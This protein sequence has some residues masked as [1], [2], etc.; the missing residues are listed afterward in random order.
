[1]AIEPVVFLI[2]G[3][4]A[5]KTNF[6]GR[7]WLCL[8]SKAG[9]LFADTLP[10]DA[11]YLVQVSQE[12]LKGKYAG[13]TPFGTETRK[14]QVPVSWKEGSIQHSGLVVLPD[15][16]GEQWTKDFQNRVWPSELDGLLTE[17]AG[18]LLFIRA[19]SERITPAIDPIKYAELFVFKAD[20]EA[21]TPKQL[22]PNVDAKTQSIRIE[23]EEEEEEAA[24]QTD[25]DDNKQNEP[26]D[27]DNTN[28]I[29]SQM[30]TQV[31][32]VDWLQCL[33]QAF[34]E[35]CGC[36]FTPRIGIVVTAWDLVP[37]DQKKVGVQGY[38]K[39][40]FPMLWQFVRANSDRFQ[41]QLFGTSVAGVDLEIDEDRKKYFDSNPRLAGFVLH[42]LNGAD[43]TSPDFT[44][45]L[46]WALGAQAQ[47]N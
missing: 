13:H 24:Q 8:R 5:G 38:L 47:S 40:I 34:D 2:G 4:D 7:L 22:A 30:P 33:R 42:S 16:P 31:V 29:D 45:P 17:K 36:E 14:C 18:C 39:H 27:D 15:R 10:D 32:L 9:Q 20:K 46:A 3:Q 44:I 41:F 12:L 6:L 37:E 1:M 21:A 11:K 28:S 43:E 19:A 23:E 25:E 35:V 26:G